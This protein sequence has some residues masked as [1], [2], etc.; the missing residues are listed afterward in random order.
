MKKNVLA[1]SIAAMIGGL[2]FAGSGPACG[3][4]PPGVVRVRFRGELN[5]QEIY[6]TDAW[7]GYGF[8]HRSPTAELHGFGPVFYTED[9][10]NWK[11]KYNVEPR[12]DQSRKHYQRHRR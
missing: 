5:V 7:T 11:P 4:L 8:D 1:L 6:I 9:N 12:N 2:G 3:P 10:V